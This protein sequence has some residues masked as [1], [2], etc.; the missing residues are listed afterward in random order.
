MKKLL[1]RGAILAK[2]DEKTK[3][4]R[5]SSFAHWVKANNEDDIAKTRGAERQVWLERFMVHSARFKAS[6]KD[7]T[8]S[9]NHSSE[10]ATFVEYHEWAAEEMDINMGP[11]KGKAWRDAG[12][13]KTSACPVTGSNDEW[14]RIYHV[15]KNWN[16]MKLA[17][18]QQVAMTTT[19]DDVT[20]DD[21]EA[22]KE[23][24][25]ALGPIEQPSSS[26][27]ASGAVAVKKETPEKP[28]NPPDKITMLAED[29]GRDPRKHYH[30]MNA[31]LL[32]CKETSV[33][34]RG[35]HKY[36]KD[37]AEDNEKVLKKSSTRWSRFLK[38]P[39]QRNRKRRH[40]QYWRK[41]F[42]T[43]RSVTI[44]CR[45][46][47]HAWASRSRKLERRPSVAAQVLLDGC[48]IAW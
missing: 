3:R 1:L 36:T 18:V 15:P 13:L 29:V 42:K 12:F 20:S 30:R 31:F 44:T 32:E 25:P 21:F 27:G 24:L 40:C 11:R 46:G 33:K 2:S 35:G 38:G 22:L 17:D 23:S 7:A 28:A 19:T 47:L 26:T 6:A 48:A 5:M 41:Q 16:R 39:R 14:L 9:K 34:L 10:Q 45:T 4:A 43:S 8:V 37:F